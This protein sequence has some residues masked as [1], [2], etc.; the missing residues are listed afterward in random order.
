MHVRNTNL[1]VFRLADK[2]GYAGHMAHAMSGR[3]AGCLPW[4]DTGFYPVRERLITGFDDVVRDG[5]SAETKSP[6]LVDVGSSHGHQ[7]VEFQKYFP[8][9]PGT[10]IL[11]DLEAVIAQANLK[12]GASDSAS[13]SDTELRY[14]AAVP[15]STNFVPGSTIHAMPHDFFTRQ[16]VRHARAYYIHACLHDW[17]DVQRRVILGHIRDAMRP[18]YSKLLINEVV[19]PDTGGA[20]WEFTGLDLLMIGACGS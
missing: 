5:E 8:D 11:H 9:H 7:L 16:P 13:D 10:L 19:L 12:L 14:G 1:D 18:D 17:P 4:M 15:G 20:H 6:F 3:R 2:L